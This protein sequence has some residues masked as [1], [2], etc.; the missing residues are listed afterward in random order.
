MAATYGDARL[1]AAEERDLGLFIG[2]P[3][4]Q[5][6]KRAH[7]TDDALGLV[8]RRIVWA[9][10]ITWVPLPLL[11]A[12]GDRLLS[13]ALPFA[14]DIECH[15]RFLAAV[16]LLILAEL[17]VQR[18]MRPMIDQFRARDL[19]PAAEVPRFETA[20]ASAHKLRNSMI[21]ELVMLF[22]VYGASYFVAQHRY[23]ELY[24]DTW[25]SPAGR[26]ALSWAGLWF[27]FVSLPIFQFLLARWYFRLF[28]WG[29]FLW[30]VAQLH[31]DLNA[32][33]PDKAGGLGFLGQ[34]LNAFVPIAAAHGVMLSGLIANRIFFAGQTL[35]QFEIQI[36]VGVLALVLIFAGPLFF[37]SP[38]LAYVRR[39]GLREYGRVAQEYVQTFEAKW[40]RSPP[41]HEE[42]LV[43]SGDIQSL[44]DLANSFAVADQMR[45]AP[46]SRA[47]LFQFVA[48]V[49]LPLTPLLFTIMPAEKLIGTFVKMVI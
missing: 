26:P 42:P 38:K 22:V 7:L 8:R 13:G 45:L 37:F 49:L 32:L 33:H 19:V 23:E 3:L 5:A 41:P 14:K 1:A 47:A 15:A 28:V 30:T 34:S 31:L 29:R 36:F 43:G 17:V 48:A 21:V 9:V 4:F 46:I 39:E 12:L 20:I 11:A 16:P 35:S 25:Y 27:V 2:G 6:L 40:I 10:A 24:H 44:A 18:R